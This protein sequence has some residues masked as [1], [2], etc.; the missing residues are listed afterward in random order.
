MVVVQPEEPHQ[1]F[2]FVFPKAA[3]DLFFAR[4]EFLQHL[5]PR[6][7]G[8]FHVLF[9]SPDILRLHLSP[10]N[11]TTP[12]A[13]DGTESAP[14][15]S[16]RACSRVP[17]CFSCSSRLC[18]LRRARLAA[19]PKSMRPIKGKPSGTSGSPW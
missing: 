13:R 16:S 15:R 11:C 18:A 5:D 1:A 10:P 14:S 8:L 9:G 2:G 17:C 19:S 12:S 3:V 7:D 4:L 6:R